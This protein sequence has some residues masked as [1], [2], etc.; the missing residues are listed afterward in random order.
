MS[1]DQQLANSLSGF[2]GGGRAGGAASGGSGNGDT[3]HLGTLICYPSFCVWCKQP[4]E[5]TW[6]SM[7]G[8]YDR[9]PQLSNNA[10]SNAGYVRGSTASSEDGKTVVAHLDCLLAHKEPVLFAL[11]HGY[12]GGPHAFSGGGG[13]GGGGGSGGGKPRN[14]LG[15]DQNGNY[16]PLHRKQTSEIRARPVEAAGGRVHSKVPNFSVVAPSNSHGRFN[17]GLGH[18]ASFPPV[19]PNETQPSVKVQQQQLPPAPG[20]ADSPFPGFD[21]CRLHQG[22]TL[23]LIFSRW[24]RITLTD[25]FHTGMTIADLADMYD[26]QTG[27]RMCALIAQHGSYRDIVRAGQQRN[28]LGRLQAFDAT[29]LPFTKRDWR[30]L[31]VRNPQDI[32]M[33][34][35][36]WNKLPN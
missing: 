30:T 10:P 31:G 36:Q 14:T 33:S 3:Q 29:S 22:M 12:L 5:T 16:Q 20:H 6:A 13:G 26:A 11:R 15:L 18:A 1:L 25:L 27:P 4:V 34:R 17:V 19:A 24:P 21:Q 32:M 23:Q 28:W 2:S 8:S 35:E 9:P 7:S